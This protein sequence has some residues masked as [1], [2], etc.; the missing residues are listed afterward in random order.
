M[1]YH[2]SRDPYLT[3]LTP[4]IPPAAHATSEDVATP[5]ISMAPTIDGCLRALCV[6]PAYSGRIFNQSVMRGNTNEFFDR[7]FNFDVE[8]KMKLLSMTH[9]D[10]EAANL[11]AVMNINMISMVPNLPFPV[12]YVYAPIGKNI[13]DKIHFIT[14]VDVYDVHETGEVWITDAVQVV[15]IGC[16]YVRY[17]EWLGS[18]NRSI[19]NQTTHKK[20][21][22]TEH[23]LLQTYNYI[24]APPLWISQS[25]NLWVKANKAMGIKKKKEP[26]SDSFK[27]E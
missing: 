17:S 11:R 18:Y 14:P 6:S 7:R 22:N 26:V 15:K 13:M 21:K 3:K 12:Y 27:K 1:L 25:L 24:S 16:I 19:Y 8:E 10:M 20:E 23:I 9:E 4:R 5:R 2:L